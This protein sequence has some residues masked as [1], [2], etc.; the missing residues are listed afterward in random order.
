MALLQWLDGVG[1][2]VPLHPLPVVPKLTLVLD[3]PFGHQAPDPGRQIPK[4]YR[5]RLD[6]VAADR[7]VE[8]GPRLLKRK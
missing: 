2:F 3:A 6:V 4:Q 8:P 1:S 7:A 5:E